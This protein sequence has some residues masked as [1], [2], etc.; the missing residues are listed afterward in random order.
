MELPIEH[1][2]SY[3]TARSTSHGTVYHHITLALDAN[4]GQ[5][6]TQ[7]SKIWILAGV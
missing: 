2:L 1:F 5:D 3:L 4:T 6:I 7:Y